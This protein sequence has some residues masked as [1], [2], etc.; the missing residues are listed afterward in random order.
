MRPM[1][2][3]VSVKFE[4]VIHGSVAGLLAAGLLGMAA[5][6]GAQNTVPDPVN[7]SSAR[8]G[9]RKVSLHFKKP[10]DGGSPIIRYEYQ[11]RVGT[12]SYPATWTPVPEFTGTVAATLDLLVVIESL[13]DGTALANGTAYAFQLRA[14]N[15]VGA[16][17]P[18]TEQTGTPQANVRATYTFGPEQGIIERRP[19]APAPRVPANQFASLLGAIHDP[20]GLD[21]ANNHDDRFT[22]EWEWIRVVAENET[23]IAGAGDRGTKITEYFLTPADVGSQIKARVRYR[24]DRYNEE[25]FVTDLFP[26]HGTILPAAACPAPTYTG[27]AAEIWQNELEI[28]DVDHDGPIPNRYGVVKYRNFQLADGTEFT[29][30]SNTYMIDEIYRATTGTEA[31]KQIFGLT[32]DLTE[33]DKNQLTLYV[34]DETYPLADATLQ[35]MAHRYEWPTTADWAT[36]I[37]RTIRLARDAVAPTVTRATISGASLAITFSEDLDDGSI[38][39]TTDFTVEV[40]GEPVELETGSRTV[41]SGSTV[42][43]TMAEAPPSGSTITVG[44]AQPGTGK[45]RDPAQNVVAEFT[46]TVTRPGSGPIVS[47]ANPP[48]APGSLVA[49]PGDSQVVFAWNAPA[50]TGGAQVTRY[51]V[52]HAEGTSVPA[53]TPWNSAG[54]ELEWTVA[55]L[56]NGQQY[57]FEV[58]AVNSAGSRGGGGH[59]RHATARAARA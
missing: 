26:A 9:D 28:R 20:D 39:A 35:T 14:V 52:R 13:A 33:T 12:G 47:P 19:Y 54:L 56:T 7:L 55:D 42:T 2:R 51:E 32:A 22:Y 41:I 1:D 24:D 58:R 25:E 44:Y 4:R 48:G 53:G 36:Y 49:T 29:A 10:D 27:G 21:T 45:L 59:D 46:A 23:V 50:S 6:A 31:G 11:A 34:C 8:P 37:T 5:P 18:G 15:G 30:G 16:G 57:A 38:P 43:L 3:F 17:M 40:G